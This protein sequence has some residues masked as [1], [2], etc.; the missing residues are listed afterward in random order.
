[1]YNV[2]T[3]I[4]NKVYIS[5][6]IYIYVIHMVFDVEETLLAGSL[7]TDVIPHMIWK[8]VLAGTRKRRVF[9]D[10]VEVSTMLKGAM[11]TKISV[12]IRSTRFT[13][14][15]I[16]ESNLDT[17]GYTFS[18]PAITDQ[19]VS[20]GNQV[21]VA[22]RISDILK[23]DQ[24][25]YNWIRLL[26]NDA[27]RAIGEYEDA[28]IRDVFLAGAG[29][30]Q[31]AAVYGTLAYDDVIDELKLQKVDSWFPDRAGAMPFLFLHPDQEADVLKDTRYVNS[32][33]YAIGNLPNLAG[34]DYLTR[35]EVDAIYAGTRVRVTDNMTAALALV[36]FPSPHP[37]YG[38]VTVHAIKRP[39][40]VR[41][42]REEIYGRQLWVAS[43]R[44]GSA[45]IQANAV[46]LITA[47]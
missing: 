14:E 34:A 15:T 42:Q 31:P 21:Y 22:F 36:V 37:D 16:S 46:G 18:T 24:P 9:K 43:V 38:A 7:P 3:F 4:S 13:A 12:P 28:A 44:Y 47:C 5:M 29:N 25:K 45:V 20:I 19:D 33:R 35:G 41:S 17:A 40:T 39:L 30:T 26:L 8:E 11:G 1:L 10:A 32:A 6:F 27:G 2:Y 23:E